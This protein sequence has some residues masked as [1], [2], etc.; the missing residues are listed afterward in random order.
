[1]IASDGVIALDLGGLDFGGLDPAATHAAGAPAGTN[2][3][4]GDNRQLARVMTG[5]R[6]IDGGA[7]AV[8]L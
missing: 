4:S 6:A 8:C 2:P 3:F 7:L 5:R 1:M